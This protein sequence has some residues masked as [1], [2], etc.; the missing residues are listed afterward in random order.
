M[1]AVGI[2]VVS[3]VVVIDAVATSSVMIAGVV[4][5][6]VMASAVTSSVVTMIVVVSSVVTMIVVISVVAMSAVVAT[7]VGTIIVVV[8]ATTAVRMLRIRT[9][10]RRMNTCRRTETNRRFRPVLAPMSPNAFA[11]PGIATTMRLYKRTETKLP[12][13]TTRRFRA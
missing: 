1:S 3:S 7:S 8:S 11:R 2:V 12:T 5:T 13:D 6:V 9:I 10:R 4:T